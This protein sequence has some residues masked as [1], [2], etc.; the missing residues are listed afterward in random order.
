MVLALTAINEKVERLS[1]EVETIE[2][3]SESLNSQNTSKLLF[4]VEFSVSYNCPL[5]PSITYNL[6]K[7][8]NVN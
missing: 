1:G 7:D 6:Y 5:S 3:P 2:A 4:I 8:N